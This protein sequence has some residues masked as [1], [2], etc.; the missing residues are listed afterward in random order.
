MS[1][2]DT[3]LRFTDGLVVEPADCPRFI[4]A[5]R[6]WRLGPDGRAVCAHT[7]DPP[8]PDDWT[9]GYRS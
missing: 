2:V 6:H 5:R 3:R 8:R 7:P 4:H 1:A 9:V